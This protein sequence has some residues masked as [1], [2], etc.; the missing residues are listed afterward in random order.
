MTWKLKTALAATALLASAATAAACP[1]ISVVKNTGY[2]VI[3]GTNGGQVQ[4]EIANPT[5]ECVIDGDN[6]TAKVSFTRPQ[7]SS[8]SRI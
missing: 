6:A 2:W 4:A 7:C 5:I 8:R 1:K 3:D